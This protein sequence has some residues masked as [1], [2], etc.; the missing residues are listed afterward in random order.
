MRSAVWKAPRIICVAVALCVGTLGVARFSDA[1][2]I[3]YPDQGPVSGFTFTS[4]SESS[5]TDPVPLYGPPM[6]FAVG[7]DF[8]PTS[9]GS[10]ATNGAA[11]ITDGQLNYTINGPTLSFNV[12]EA[13]DFTLVGGG[14]ATTSAL[15]GLIL[16]ATVTQIS[17]IAVPPIVLTPVNAS[18]GF[19]LVAN[20]GLVQPWSLNATMD[21]AGQLAGLG[22]GPGD[23]ATAID[24]VIDNQLI[25]I[26]EQGT[27]AFIAKK[28]FITEII[29]VPEPAVHLLLFSGAAVIGY[30]ATRRR[31]VPAYAMVAR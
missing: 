22:Y 4:I 12:F 10:S 23:I 17:G 7:L 11:D 30:F 18:V 19:N 26:S 27:I 31:R 20:P 14:T 24:V 6:A 28:E 3:N 13:G 29:P 9:F 16:R 2:T 1:A 5:S 21:V 15:A 25:T 8:N